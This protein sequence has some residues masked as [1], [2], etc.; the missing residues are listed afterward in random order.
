MDCSTTIQSDDYADFILGYYFYL[1]T[2]A[3]NPNIVC[4]NNVNNQFAIVQVPLSQM[5]DIN[6]ENLPY[7]LIPK[8]YTTLDTTSIEASGILPTLNQPYL[9]A[10]GQGVLVGFIDTGIDYKN[11]AF[12]NPGGSTR[13]LGIWDQTIQSENSGESEWTQS[14]YGAEYTSEQIDQAL[15]SEDPYSIV[16]S[17]DE[18]GHGTFI[19]GVAAGSNLPEQNFTG[20]APE[21]SIA[22]VKLK[23]AKTYLK[24][25]FLVSDDVNVFQESDIMMG[26]KYLLYLSRKYSLPLSLCISVGTNSGS[27]DGTSAL[28]QHL[29]AVSNTSS[30]VT[31][32]A[33]GN[34]AGYGHH[35][36]G[37]I[38]A[39]TAY[40]DVE[41][42][43]A[44]DENGFTIELW[45]REPEVYSI[46]FISPTGE[47]IN[48]IPNIPR[49]SDHRISFVLERTVITVNY[50]L[51]VASSG[52]Q[53]IFMRFEAPTPGIWQIRVYSSLFINGQYHMWL[54]VHGFISP[55]TYF[56]R[57]NP[58]TTI[59]EPGNA[60]PPITVSTYNHQNSS[61]YIHSSRGYTRMGA[62]KPDLAAPGVDVSGLALLP[63]R[64]TEFP[65][66][67]PLTS[68]TGSSI[69]A[70]HTAGAAAVLLS[71]GIT[72]D[73]LPGINTSVA[74]AYLIRGATRNPALTYPN[75]EWGF[76]LLNL[77]NSFIQLRE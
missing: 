1:Q 12:R 68:K 4:M 17:R 29:G 71:W 27:H 45:A 55:E 18:D 63:G 42:R 33:A 24:D 56:L 14:P 9:N 41:L 23:Q 61:L 54:P 25:F 15:N 16:P 70:A 43:V 2:L 11:P 37:S 77:Y 75:K 21:S 74:K 73:N 10:R 57:P 6:L 22:V 76:G 49:G 67:L 7:T 31:V 64:Q 39:D 28:P 32:V 60:S 38:P 5:P 8:L 52:S 40:E 36:F 44:P 19:A 35:Y 65:Q 69:A 46:G 66:T 59:T 51:S 30:L 13:I 34:E 26:I 72:E 3:E 48:R 58:D 53:L 62:I 20:A 50:Q 47:V